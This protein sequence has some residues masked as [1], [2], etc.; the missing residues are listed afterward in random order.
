MNVTFLIGN[1]FDLNL[2]LNTRYEDFYDYYKKNTKN[3]DGL[4]FES[5]HTDYSKWSDMELGLS[6][7][8]SKVPKNKLSVFFDEKEELEKLL[9]EYLTGE[10]ARISYTNEN[11]LAEMFRNM[12][13]DFY[14][15]LNQNEKNHYT[16]IVA[17]T[18]NKINYCFVTFNYTTTLDK[19]V[20]I[21]NERIHSFSVHVAVNTQYT[22]TLQPPIH[23]HGSLVEDLVLGVDNV[24]Q[25]VNEE[26]KDNEEVINYIIKPTVNQ[27]LGENKQEIAQ[28]LINH[29][30]YVCLFGLSIGET[31]KTWWSFLANWLSQDKNRRL[32]IFSV[33]ENTQMSGQTKIRFANTIKALFLKRAEWNEPENANIKDQIL[34]L[35]NTKLFDLK[36]VIFTDDSV[37][38]ENGAIHNLAG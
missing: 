29:S 20:K 19:M 33:D 16:K 28:D 8:L 18:R 1:G 24:E 31:D 7:L 10:E 6:N 36:P 34:V 25:I 26:Y 13:R 21:T 17:E 32:V 14:N 12:V 30:C 2:G 37:N 27:L 23:I 4:I 15:Y 11:E 5:L 35:K 9:I 3:Q 38:N 22:D